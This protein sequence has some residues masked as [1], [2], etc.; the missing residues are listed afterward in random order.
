MANPPV[1]TDSY[2][3][4]YGAAAVTALLVLLLYLATLAPTTA[5]WDTSEYITAAY[6]MGIPHPPGNPFFVLIG[7]FFALLPIAPTVALRVN[8]LAALASA[9]SAGLWFL[10]A[11][12]SAAAWLAARW[13][14]IAVGGAAALIG[15]TAFTVWNQSVVNEK[16]YTVSLV[17]LA[18]SSWLAMRWADARDG[19][20]AD[21][22]LVLAA[23]VM[24]LGYANHTAGLLVGPAVTALVLARRPRTIVRWR[25][26]L[27]CAGA[28]ALGMTPFAT[29][30]LRASRF[31]AINEGEV[32]GCDGRVSADCVLSRVTWE[33]F[34]YN[35]NRIQYA[36]PPLLD[37]QAPFA[38]QLGMWWTYFRWQWLRDPY[39]ERPLAQGTLAALFLLLGLYGG[40]AQW[41]RDRARFWYMGTLTATLS[42]VLVY[43]MNFKYGATQS[44]QLQDV[45]REVRDRDYFFIWSFSA[46]GV[47]VAL[48]LAALWQRGAAALAARGRGP[49]TQLVSWPRWAAAGVPLVAVALLPLALNWSAASRRGETFT[50]EFAHDLLNSVEPYGVL[51]TGGDNDTFP[52]WYAQ[53][54]EGVRKDV[55]VACSCLLPAEWYARQLIRRPVHEYDAAAG[56]AL[57]R[58]TA[59]PKPAVPVLGLTTREADS[60]PGFVHL[61]EPR[62]FRHAGIDAQV[63]SGL[64]TRDELLVLQMIKDTFPARPVYFA[65][66]GGGYGLRLGLGPYLVRQ[67]LVRKLVSPAPATTSAPAAGVLPVAGQG[68]VDVARTLALWDT[69]YAAPAA[70]AA[71]GEWV[72]RANLSAPY[73][74]LDTGVVLAETLRA[75]GREGDAARLN[76][77]V[78][79]MAEAVRL[80]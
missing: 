10:V 26:L 65:T 36:K 5:M 47:W 70:L 32:T 38:G 72:D 22:L 46:W 59:W 40:A 55:T 56:P 44:P 74:Y 16:V 54:V 80:R 63:D 28:L 25:L 57:Y 8:V 69:V 50:R 58:G 35:F 66:T 11:E 53:E 15:A 19:A 67:G 9:L 31:P 30:P 45:P 34:K 3:P 73:A 64:V 79:R 42:V 43:Y 39:G 75:L 7:R 24:G 21:R 17:G 18:L 12:R 60:V 61:S 76:A 77:Q 78:E 29:Q 20:R 27:A 14:R 49:A 48:G 23:Y 2:R 51:I 52:L 33:R 4:S 41:R 68:W 13:Q 37:R 6:V 62:L 71:R 1:Q